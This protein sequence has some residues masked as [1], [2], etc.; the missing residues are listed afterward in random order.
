MSPEEKYISLYGDRGQAERLVNAKKSNQSSPVSSPMMPKDK[1]SPAQNRANSTS[2]DTKKVK[3]G[4]S[5]FDKS[6]ARHV[7]PNSMRP[8]GIKKTGFMR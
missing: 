1:I 8:S 4:L 6:P 7:T 5:I 3:A 2:P